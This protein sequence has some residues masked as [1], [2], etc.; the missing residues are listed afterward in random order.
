MR[1]VGSILVMLFVCSV[2]FAQ[3]PPANADVHNALRQ[4]R[5]TMEKA[6]NERDL[7]TVL[8]NVTSSVIFTAMNGDVCYG[9]DAVKVYFNKMMNDPGHIVQSI[10]THFEADA[11][12]TLYGDSTGIAFGNSNDHYVLTNGQ[13]FDIRGRWTCTLVKVDG[14][15]LIGSFHYSASIFDN[16]IMTKMRAMLLGGGAVGVVIA[17]FIGIVVGRATTAK[18]ASV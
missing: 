11:L 1:R 13:K 15:W 5:V 17:L 10:N 9:R 4:L 7:N 8:A 16:P 18:K 12:T 14:K 2:A 6:L 3:T